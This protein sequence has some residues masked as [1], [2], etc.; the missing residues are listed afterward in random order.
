MKNKQYLCVGE[1]WA[2]TVYQNIPMGYC[3][4]FGTL[5]EFIEQLLPLQIINLKN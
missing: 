2:D 4:T 3:G 5:P 1:N